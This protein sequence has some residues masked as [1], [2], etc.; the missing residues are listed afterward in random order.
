MSQDSVAPSQGGSHAT[1][2]DALLGNIERELFDAAQLTVG[3]TFT[4]TDVE[5]ES[6][7]NAVSQDS[8]Y[9]P[10]PMPPLQPSPRK[11]APTAKSNTA[12]SRFSYSKLKLLA[13]KTYT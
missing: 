13:K 5:D 7:T 12:R 4:F 3:P 1:E 8:R 9:V 2:G 10:G 11:P 6:S